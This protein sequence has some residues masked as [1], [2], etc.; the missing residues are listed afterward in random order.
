MEPIFSIRQILEHQSPAF[1]N[2]MWV[3]VEVFLRPENLGFMSKYV[4]HYGW[5]FIHKA[6]RIEENIEPKCPNETTFPPILKE[7]EQ[8]HLVIGKWRKIGWPNA[9]ERWCR[10]ISRVWAPRPR[11]VWRK[12]NR[13]DEWSRQRID[14]VACGESLP[15]EWPLDVEWRGISHW[16]RSLTNPQRSPENM[17]YDEEL[18]GKTAR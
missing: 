2:Q 16:W 14:G 11:L 8:K 6:K 3:H 12:W 13:P 9:G 10:G 5:P 15:Q 7:M 17:V 1:W 4:K 18:I